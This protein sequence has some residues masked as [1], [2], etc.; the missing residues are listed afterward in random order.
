MSLL[1]SVVL[2]H[3]VSPYLALCLVYYAICPLS[4][5][6]SSIAASSSSRVNV[7]MKYSALLCQCAVTLMNLYIEV[8]GITNGIPSPSNII[9]KVSIGTKVVMQ[10]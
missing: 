10:L 9:V 7:L 2:P 5:Q 3:M 6:L 8:H 1:I 4:Q